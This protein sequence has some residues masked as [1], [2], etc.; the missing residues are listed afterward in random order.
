MKC[1]RSRLVGWSASI[2]L[3]KLRELSDRLPPS[4][5]ATVRRLSASANQGGGEIDLALQVRDP[6]NIVELELALEVGPIRC[7]R[8]SE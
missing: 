1:W 7:P 3:V 5:N 8:A 4:D 6:E 2:G